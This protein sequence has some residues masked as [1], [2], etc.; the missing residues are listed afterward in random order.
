M[1]ALD[2][3]H[4]VRL[5]HLAC[6][7]LRVD[8]AGVGDCRAVVEMFKEKSIRRFYSTSTAAQMGGRFRTEKKSG[9]GPRRT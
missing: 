8:H 5:E 7:S 4:R 1:T 6:V 2:R 3:S 9:E